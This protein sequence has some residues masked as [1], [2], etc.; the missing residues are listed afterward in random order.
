MYYKALQTRSTLFLCID[1][2]SRACAIVAPP[3]TIEVNCK[4]SVTPTPFWLHVLLRSGRTWLLIKNVMRE[5]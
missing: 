4:A 2:C 5:P 1:I 3:V